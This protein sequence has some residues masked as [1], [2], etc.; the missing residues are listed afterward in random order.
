MQKYTVKL[1]FSAVTYK[2]IT[3]YFFLQTNNIFF[4]FKS[5]FFLSRLWTFSRI[6]DYYLNRFGSLLNGSMG[7]GFR[8]VAEAAI[9]PSQRCFLRWSVSCLKMPPV[10]GVTSGQTCEEP[11]VPNF[12]TRIQILFLKKKNYILIFLI[13]TREREILYFVTGWNCGRTISLFFFLFFFA[14]WLRHAN[15]PDL[16]QT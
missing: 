16:K 2:L 14:M 6:V 13:S 5:L 15:E 9:G 1:Q 8:T 10:H 4:F 12:L 11:N 7:L 3:N